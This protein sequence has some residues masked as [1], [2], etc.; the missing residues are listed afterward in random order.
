[1]K[2]LEY[3]K[4]LSSNKPKRNHNLFTLLQKYDIECYTC[5]NHGHLERDCKLMTPTRKTVAIMYQDT[6]Q[7]KYWREK[8]E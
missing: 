2:F 8:E 1:M 5:N 7:K 3:K 6:K 4:K